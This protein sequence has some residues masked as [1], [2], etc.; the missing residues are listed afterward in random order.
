VAHI[1]LAVSN[2]ARSRG[3]YETYFGFDPGT[4]MVAEDGVLLI[5]GPG[6]VLLALGE[7]D[8]PIEL[9]SFLH[10][11]F[12]DAVNPEEVRTFRDRLAGDGVEIVEFWDEPD[13]ASVKCKDP[14]GSV[15]E[16]AWE[17]DD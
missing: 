5:E 3:F 11:G 16:F 10:F 14:D 17:P 8:E 1:A 4:A 13:Y 7:T 6:G 2:Q 15:I 12:G 9:P